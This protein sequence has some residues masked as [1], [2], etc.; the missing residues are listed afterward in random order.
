M[1]QQVLVGIAESVSIESRDNVSEA[2]STFDG[3]LRAYFARLPIGEMVRDRCGCAPR[4][5][6]ALSDMERMDQSWDYEALKRTNDGYSP[7]GGSV[8][9]GGIPNRF[10]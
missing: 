7:A 6:R 8:L 3:L 1:V 2:Q 10:L 9:R 5:Q 4:G